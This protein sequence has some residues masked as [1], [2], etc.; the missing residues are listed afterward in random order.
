LDLS[1]K[2]LNFY[3]LRGNIWGIHAIYFSVN[4]SNRRIPQKDGDAFAF[5]NIKLKIIFFKANL[6]SIIRLH[7]CFSMILST[8][9]HCWQKIAGFR[10]QS[11]NHYTMKIVSEY[12]QH[13]IQQRETTLNIRFSNLDYIKIR[14]FMC[15]VRRKLFKY[16]DIWCLKCSF[17]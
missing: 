3:Y 6:F 5:T 1:L 10:V 15:R 2:L 17:C 11:A 9:R 16:N 12:E 4:P 7:F 14:N 8:D 13:S